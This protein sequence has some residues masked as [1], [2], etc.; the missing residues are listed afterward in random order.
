MVTASERTPMEKPAGSFLAIYLNDH[1]AGA[2]AGVGRSRAL[3]Q[4]HRGRPGEERLRRLAE[5]IAADRGALLS[6]MAS[7]GIPVRHYKSIAMSVAERAGR[8][9]FNGRLK[10][11]SPLTDMVEYEFLRLA[12]EGKAAGWRTLLTLADRTPDLDAGELE[13]LLH[14]AQTQIDLLE[15]LR[16]SAAAD[17]FTSGRPA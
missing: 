17:V 4:A 2:A 16:R 5:E 7:L 8:L 11:R 13:K 3:A 15:D 14:R 6:I 1:L 10:E 9:K 12:V